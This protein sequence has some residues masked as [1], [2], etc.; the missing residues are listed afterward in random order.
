MKILKRF[1]V[2][3]AIL[4]LAG[5]IVYFCLEPVVLGIARARL[6]AV[7]PGSIVKIGSADVRLFSSISLQDISVTRAGSFELTAKDIVISY[8]PL[9][10]IRGVVSG[11]AVSSVSARVRTRQ[12]T[13]KGVFSAGF[14][15]KQE[16]LR[17]LDAALETCQSQGLRV[18]DLC[19]N[20]REGTAGG[21]LFVGSLIYNK[22]KLSGLQ[23]DLRLE[24]AALFVDNIRAGILGG[25]MSGSA[26]VNL[27][28]P[29]AYRAGVEFSRLDL[30]RFAH[31][32]GFEEKLLLIGAADGALT[33]RGTGGV[34]ED[35]SGGFGSIAPGG[36]VIVKDRDFLERVAQA[37]DQPLDIIMET[38]KNYRYN[39]GGAKISRSGDNLVLDVQL[40]GP[41][42]RQTP[43]FIWYDFFRDRT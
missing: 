21:K 41:A 6:R 3:V 24:A 31:D 18:D 22:G 43:S 35:V 27:K 42:G 12:L 10:I 19:L 32:F 1:A 9:E 33:A 13:L 17:Y 4:V 16:T 37:A 23:A 2:I 7:L 30:S 28:F 39:T 26:Q 29:L 20:V 40:E 36:T 34:L 38:F 15:L 11:V 8:R 25:A 5:G 14:D